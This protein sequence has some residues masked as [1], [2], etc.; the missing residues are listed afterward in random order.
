MPLSR[1]HLHVAT[2]TV[3]FFL[4]GVRAETDGNLDIVLDE[5]FGPE[6]VGWSMKDWTNPFRSGLRPDESYV[7]LEDGMM[8]VFLGRGMMRVE[9]SDRYH[10]M[11]LTRPLQLYADFEIECLMKWDRKGP[12]TILE[13]YVTLHS[14][15]IGVATMGIGTREARG[16]ILG[17][18]TRTGGSVPLAGEGR[19]RFVRKNRIVQVYWNGEQL[20]EKEALQPLTSISLTVK[21][22]HKSRIEGSFAGLDRLRVFLPKPSVELM[23]QSESRPSPNLVAGGD[24][25][26]RAKG[27]TE[28]ELDNVVLAT[29]DLKG[30]GIGTLLGWETDIDG[31]QRI[32]ESNGSYLEAPW[33]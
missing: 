10:G 26:N 22:Y 32:W 14:K 30:V 5:K 2:L 29:E 23:T 15:R 6:C 8:K 4:C 24:L 25:E 12:G 19:I 11:A 33:V 18:W 21:T 16:T 27:A 20:G 28:A 9:K 13:A 7:R 3:A 1:I 17:S 31:V